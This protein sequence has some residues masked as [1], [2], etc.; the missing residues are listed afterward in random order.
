MPIVRVHIRPQW[1]LI[2]HG[3]E[4]LGP[5][6]LP[7]L[8]AIDESGRL[9][10]AAQSL[11]LSYRHAWNLLKR[12]EAL[13]GQALV[14]LER[15]RGARLSRL[16]K[17][18]V[19]AERRIHARLEPQ[20][21]SLAAETETEINRTLQGP[22]P[23][24]RIH[25]SHGFAVAKLRER[26]EQCQELR[27]EFQFRG[28][29]DA[30]AALAERNCE[31]AGFHLP[32]DTLGS[33]AIERF[34]PWFDDT[35]CVLPFVIRR[36]GL[37]LPAGNPGGLAAITDL[38]RTGLR[39]VNRQPGS[40][41][42]ELLDQ[43]LRRHGIDAMHLSGYR[44]EEFTHS[45]VAAFVASGMA[46]V[47]FGVEAAARQF[48]LAFVPLAEEFYS[49]I[50]RRELLETVPVRMLVNLLADPAFQHE[51]DAIA[52]YRC[53][54]AGEIWEMPQAVEMWQRHAS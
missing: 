53:F 15:G 30:L 46:D 42:R 50:C 16:G 35:Q 18:L 33:Q 29:L 43:L 25:A 26:L 3:E 21:M 6:C 24:L 13:F 52:G 40:G 48:G 54:H 10:H 4:S 47:G 14:E 2:S 32:C 49:L 38:A 44:H 31:V 45:A 22:V 39:F 7:L 23:L 34:R 17:C 9:T 8:I 27:W 37:I 19:N 51:I 12:W 11:G 5:H 41:T 28:G 20:L 1:D 36:Q